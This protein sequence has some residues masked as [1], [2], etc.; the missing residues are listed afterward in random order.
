[1]TQS[2]SIGHVLRVTWLHHA[3]PGAGVVDRNS[4]SGGRRYGNSPRTVIFGGLWWPHPLWVDPA[5]DL[6][7]TTPWPSTP[8][9]ASVG[10]VVRAAGQRFVR[11]GAQELADRGQ[12]ERA[13]AAL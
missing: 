2:F 11:S 7:A 6:P 9:S 8:A 13:G 10:T 3:D 4:L 5:L 12:E 1:L